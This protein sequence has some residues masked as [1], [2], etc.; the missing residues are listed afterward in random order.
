MLKWQ[1]SSQKMLVGHKLGR[2][3]YHGHPSIA[4]GMTAFHPLCF[5]D[6][7]NQP[8]AYKPNTTSDFFLDIPEELIQI[9]QRGTYLVQLI[10]LVDEELYSLIP[11][12]SISPLA[13][14]Q[15]KL[16]LFYVVTARQSMPKDLCEI[17]LSR[18]P[19][20]VRGHWPA[21]HKSNEE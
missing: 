10:Q 2:I 6:K 21:F 13:C 11:N 3:N 12:Y 15:P 9:V 1:I 16:H 5:I 19:F 4:K 17:P 18:D 7:E 14:M 8:T 20:S